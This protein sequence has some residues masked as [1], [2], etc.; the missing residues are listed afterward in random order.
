M[1]LPAGEGT[2]V[3]GQR[4]IHTRLPPSSDEKELRRTPVTRDT[5]KRFM[6]LSTIIV[7]GRFF[8][9]GDAILPVKPVSGTAA[10]IRQGPPG[11]GPV[12]SC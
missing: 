2:T 8:L 6:G 4:G 12:I 9:P 11:A 1:P 10:E 3:A 7:I 5:Y